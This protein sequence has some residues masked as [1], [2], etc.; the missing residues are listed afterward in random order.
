MRLWKSYVC[1]R[2]CAT[3]K[4]LLLTERNLKSS[5][6]TLDR[7]EGLPALEFWDL[8]VSVLGNVSRV[9]DRSGQPDN[10]VH[11]VISLKRISM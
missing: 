6:W 5:L 3:N 11:N 1:S 10:D 7:L 2:G 8:I 4:L 9:S